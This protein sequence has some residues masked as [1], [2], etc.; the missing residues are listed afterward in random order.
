VDVQPV[1]QP[2]DLIVYIER[3]MSPNDVITLRVLRG[4]TVLDKQLTLGA[5]T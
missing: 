1:T 4:T 2:E 3:Y 5:R